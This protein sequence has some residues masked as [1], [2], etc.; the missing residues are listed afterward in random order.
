MTSFALAVAAVVLWNAA[1][2]GA[3]KESLTQDSWAMWKAA[4]AASRFME[5]RP[6]PCLVTTG[7]TEA[8]VEQVLGKGDFDWSFCSGGVGTTSLCFPAYGLEVMFQTDRDGVSR[9]IEV[10]WLAAC[11]EKGMT[12]QELERILGSTD[13]KAL[14]STPLT[15][16]FLTGSGLRGYWTRFDLGIHV[17]LRADGNGVLR[18]ESIEFMPRPE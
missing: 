6:S 7:M 12:V 18:A 5:A 8:D 11:I 16:L 10:N 4:D 9:V 1:S 15:C 3:A 13:S 14:T 17:H 2:Q